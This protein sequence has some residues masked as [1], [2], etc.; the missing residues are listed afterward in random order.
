VNAGRNPHFFGGIAMVTAKSIDQ[1][2]CG[3]FNP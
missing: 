3:R 1:G 2:A